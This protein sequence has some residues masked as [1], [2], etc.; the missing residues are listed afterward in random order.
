EHNHKLSKFLYDR[1]PVN[2]R[3]KEG[4]FGTCQ[5]LLRYGT[6]SSEMRQLVAD[7]FGKIL[8]T[9]D[10]HNYRR[11]CRPAMVTRAMDEDELL[12]LF[13]SPQFDPNVYASSVFGVRKASEVLRLVN[14]KILSLDASIYQHVA[15]HHKELLKRAKDIDQLHDVL[16]TTESKITNLSQSLTK[17]KHKVAA[18]YIALH[19]QIEQFRRLQ[20]S[21]DLLRKISRAAL[22]TKR[23]QCPSSRT[24]RFAR[25]AS[26]SAAASA[27][28]SSVTTLN[29]SKSVF[30]PR[31][32]VYLATFNVRTLKQAGQQVAL[33]RTLDSLCI[34]VR[35]LSETRTQDASTVIELTAPSLSSRFR[36]RPSGDAEAAAP[37]HAGVGIVLSE[38]A[39]ASLVDW[40]PLDSRLGAVRLATSPYVDNELNDFVPTFHSVKV[41]HN[42]GMLPS[43]VCQLVERWQTEFD[44]ILASAVDV[45][46]L[47]QRVRSRQAGSPGGPVAAGPGRASLPNVGS[48]AA[49]FY[50]AIWTSLDGIMDKLERLTYHC[51]LL[52][53]TLLKKRES[54]VNC[55]TIVRLSESTEPHPSLAEL[56]LHDLVINWH[57]PDK[58]A[59]RNTI[60][61]LFAST[62]VETLQFK[63]R[64]S[65]ETL[66]DE[67]HMVPCERI[68]E[69]EAQLRVNKGFLGWAAGRLSERL[70]KIS[71]QSPQVKE[72]LD[73]EYPKLLKLVIDLGR[74]VRQT[75]LH[76]SWNDSSC[77]TV[78]V[79]GADVVP[80]C[81]LEA[82]KPFETAYLSKSLSRLFDQVSMAFSTSHSS[83]GLD[84]QELDGIVQSAGNELAY[85]TVHYDLLCKVSRNIS[86]VV[87]LF[88][89]KVESLVAVGPDA[90]QVMNP[91]TISQQ[92]NI[93]LIN[94]LCSFGTQL[95][96]TCTRR[97]RNLPVMQSARSEH[98]SSPLEAIFATLETRLNSM[99]ISIFQPLL[100]SISDVIEELMSTMHG[101]DF[102]CCQ[103]EDVKPSCSLYMKQLQ[104][105]A[106]SVVPLT[107]SSSKH[108]FF[109]IALRQDF[110]SRARK[111]YLS[112][113][114]LPPSTDRAPSS[115]PKAGCFSCGDVALQSSVLPYMTR[116]IDMF[117]NNISL[118]RPVSEV[119]RIRLAADCVEFELA[120]SPLLSSA[121]EGA[122]VS[123]APEAC[124]KLRAFRPV[125]LA[126][127]DQILR[128]YMQQKTE[129]TL[130]IIQLP[131]SLVCQHLFSRA[132]DEI[133]S[134]HD[135]AGWSTTRYI[136]WVLARSDE[137]ERLTF[138]RNGL[139]A[140]AHEVQIRQQ[141]QYPAMYLVLRDFLQH[142][143]NQPLKADVIRK[144]DGLALQPP[145]IACT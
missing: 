110:V 69:L 134:P 124:M 137:S 22:L 115:V 25:P 56:L 95:G 92:N 57:G 9:E 94:L 93:N 131:P 83:V 13:H 23:I 52:G 4:E 67:D 17:L 126:D 6:P 34:D 145:E 16:Q 81:L 51:R 102:A 5:A 28:P 58:V 59:L 15:S 72:A 21:C 141:R 76:G 73:C 121:T 105:S 63:S 87:A 47:T 118:V 89:T 135:T 114:S 104:A 11:K 33:A 43:V 12:T 78:G 8:T 79:F 20:R 77:P 38:R 40:I 46:R 90:N 113:L 88:A 98:G 101:E 60:V 7:E 3:L 62:N 19:T 100:Q 44:S 85:A 127:S 53:V 120:V 128:A 50:V 106:V 32:P 70:L 116:W 55:S 130:D 108:L 82:V 10:I 65:A 49:A 103:D 111:Q 39:E 136:S 109:S 48:Q 122:L 75:Q 61:L 54:S 24:D 143:A 112:G 45:D 117:L 139:A 1:L 91:Q 84:A 107:S 29:T 119:G 36:L 18:P 14:E 68:A 41:F 99:C 26:H 27:R 71:E 35:C 86:K 31:K 125:L 74:R 129:P 96:W 30:K 140:Y 64:M 144:S 138:L 133:R 2:R 97:L 37:G 142:F 80:A 132:P 123:F 42:L 66:S